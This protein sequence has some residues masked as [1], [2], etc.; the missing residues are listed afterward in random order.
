MTAEEDDVLLEEVLDKEDLGDKLRETFED[1]REK[2]TAKGRPLSFKQREFA[3][4]VLEG[5]RYDPPE[6]YLNLA[7]SGTLARG[8]EVEL[9]VKDKPL[10][11]PQRRRE[12]D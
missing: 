9:L 6:E 5:R 12:E 11:P 2:T 4:A 8:R 7:S 3:H 1:I 10:R